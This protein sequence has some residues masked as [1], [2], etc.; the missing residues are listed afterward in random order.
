MIYLKYGNISNEFDAL[1]MQSTIKSDSLNS[2]SLRGYIA[3][4]SL[5]A[6]RQWKI[7]LSA[8]TI[9]YESKLRFLENWFISSDKKISLN[10]SNWR[11]VFV[12]SGDMPIEF[13]DNAKFLPEFSFTAI[14]KSPNT[15]ILVG[16]S[17]YE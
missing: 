13:L 1:I 8:D 16:E 5:H 7:V 4:K 15:D 10:N 3:E 2:V 17:F 12:E 9:R 14:S 6:R 11:D